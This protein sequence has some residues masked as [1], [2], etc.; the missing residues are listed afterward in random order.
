MA[1][2][3]PIIDL[4]G[5]AKEIG[6]QHGYKCK[7]RI[8]KNISLYENVFNLERSKLIKLSNH[9]EK[10]INAFNPKYGIEIESIAEG[11]EVE[12]FW[13]YALNSR[14]EIINRM[15]DECTAVYFKNSSLLGQNWDWLQESEDLSV[16]LRMKFE[17]G[18]KILTMTE[19]GIIGKIGL[20]NYGIGVCLN[21]LH[22]EKES[23]GVPVHILLRNI[24][25]S[26]T[27]EAAVRN[28]DQSDKGT[29]SNIL[30]GDKNGNY[31]DL[32]L[33]IE[34]VF[35]YPTKDS[36][37][38]HTNHYLAEGFDNSV[39]DFA[40]SIQ[41]FAHANS[42]AKGLSGTTKDEMK[43]I[44][45]DSSDPE[46]PICRRY[47]L[48]EEFGTVG[49]VTT[50]LMDLRNKTLELTKGNPFENEFSTIKFIKLNN[51]N[52]KSRKK[53]VLVKK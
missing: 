43:L 8:E 31:L 29:A 4:E 15:I 16:I 32:E 12:P 30:I 40:G 28:I 48:I 27:I 26:R 44:L 24:L 1:E 10:K 20:N 34:K 17:N 38:I 9:Y 22:I 52:S 5:T 3:F 11:A 50:I 47:S 23:L 39:D 35:F 13:I 53:A 36:I 14:T 46:L 18:L 2:K 41:R 7:D 25:E 21:Y 49:T 42:L 45:L 6:Y 37:F 33:A 51:K 19:P